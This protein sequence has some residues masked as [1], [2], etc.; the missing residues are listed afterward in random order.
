[1]TAYNTMDSALAGLAEGLQHD[2]ISRVVST[3]CAFGD[4][5]Y[6][7]TNDGETAHN[8]HSGG[9]VPDGVFMRVQKYPGKY[10][11]KDVATIIRKGLVWV[12]VAAAV[13]ANVALY[14]TSAGVWTTTSAGNTACKAKTRSSTAGAG[15]A[16]IELFDN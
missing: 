12:P 14:I 3:E 8:T 15:L 16:L 11:A 5:A 10:E 6:L 4:A 1:M 9:L 2:K 7:P 13:Q